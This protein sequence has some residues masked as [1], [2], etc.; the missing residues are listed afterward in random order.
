MEIEM[1]TTSQ[2]GTNHQAERVLEQSLKSRGNVHA[3]RASQRDFQQARDRLKRANRDVGETAAFLA[4]SLTTVTAIQA[5]ISLANKE[6]EL[7]REILQLAFLVYIAVFV[8]L[9]VLGTLRVAHALHR[10]ARAEREIDRTKKGI[11][12]FCSVEE[13]PGIEE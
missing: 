4:A 7:S 9:L 3:C 13:W 10:R 12:D 5:V 6:L 11:F 2:F 1:E 8:L